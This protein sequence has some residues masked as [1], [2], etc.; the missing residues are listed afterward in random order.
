MNLPWQTPDVRNVVWDPSDGRLGL[1][2]TCEHGCLIL[3]QP[4][5][6]DV[7]LAKIVRRAVRENKV[8]LDTK[9]LRM[10]EGTAT[11]AE[12]Y[13]VPN[14]KAVAWWIQHAALAATF[15]ECETCEPQAH[16]DG[17]FEEFARL[18]GA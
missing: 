14:R 16:S 4:A 8:V 10:I 1:T 3:Y 13:P 18:H 7:E 2:E 9:M 11:S 17:G 6:H 15:S 12:L 5:G